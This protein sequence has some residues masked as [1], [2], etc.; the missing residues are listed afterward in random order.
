MFTYILHGRVIP[1]RSD[2]HL[3]LEPGWLR[4]FRVQLPGEDAV[5]FEA[6]ISISYSQLAVI[7]K[8]EAKIEDLFTL[9][10][11]IDLFVR[12]FLDMSAYLEG[13]ALDVEITSVIGHQ[14]GEPW[15]TLPVWTVFGV[16]MPVLNQRK[17]ERPVSYEELFPFLLDA[18]PQG[19]AGVGVRMVAPRT[20]RA[21]LADLRESIK[22]PHDTAFFTYRAI[23]TIRQFFVHDEDGTDARCSWERMAN[24][25]RIESSWT[26]DLAPASQRQRHGAGLFMDEEARVQAMLRAWLVVDRFVL[27]VKNEFKPLPATHDIVKSN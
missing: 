12:S 7:V 13:K 17:S 8:S 14:D 1:E 10:N 19:E 15:A 5:E 24:A 27:F 3:Q 2:V 23:E 16:E 11:Y 22:S 9:R 21:A 6:S 26:S 20:L 18:P 25:L 4:P